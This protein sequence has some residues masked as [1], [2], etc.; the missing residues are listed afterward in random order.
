[1]VSPP[2]PFQKGDQVK[3]KANNSIFGI[4]KYVMDD[5]RICV[6]IFPNG[7]YDV[8]SHNEYELA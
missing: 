3:Y 6:S 7:D 4:V 2:S 5:G 8:T 1:M